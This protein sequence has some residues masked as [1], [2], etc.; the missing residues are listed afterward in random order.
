MAQQLLI[1]SALMSKKKGTCQA[2]QPNLDGDQHQQGLPHSSAQPNVQAP[3]KPAASQKRPIS[4][5]VEGGHGLV[6]K[7][8]SLLA[9]GLLGGGS[10]EDVVEVLSISGVLELLF[11][12]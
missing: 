12:V 2:G 9:G 10:A 7:S 3:H 5:H 8:S 4:G 1:Q 11:S 6:Q